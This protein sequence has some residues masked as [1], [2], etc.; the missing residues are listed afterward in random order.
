MHCQKQRGKLLFAPLKPTPKHGCP[1]ACWSIDY[2]P[3]L[4]LTTT[5]YRHV[6]LCVDVF[7]KWVE[8]VPMR[9]KSSAEVWEVLYGQI[10][11]RYGVPWEFRSD[12]GK[13]FAGE[14]I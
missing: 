8:A 3:M 1:F 13:E 5:G 9:T 2:L 11:A 10:I 7:S 14:V 4:P 12:R 6:L